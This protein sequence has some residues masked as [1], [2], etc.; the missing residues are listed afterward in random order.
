MIQFAK[1]LAFTTL[2]SCTQSEFSTT[3][4]TQAAASK[5][6]AAAEQVQKTPTPAEPT[7]SPQPEQADPKPETNLI[8]A[9][10]RCSSPCN[11]KKVMLRNEKFNK[12]IQVVLC[13]QQRYDIL[14]GETQ[15]GPFYKVGDI[16][17]HGQDHCELVNPQFADLRS[18]DDVTSGN[19]PTCVVQS[20]GSVTDLPDLF[21]KKIYK[22]SRWGEAFEFT[23]AT[24][25]GIHTSCWYECGV[26]FP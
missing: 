23:D 5:A 21:G 15:S 19:C 22:R 17:G 3:P 24:T 14:M 13:S 2:I 6:P 11:G 4:K 25:S 9:Y 12:W 20:A 7:A 26:S 10:G 18:D 1:L 16:G 8:P